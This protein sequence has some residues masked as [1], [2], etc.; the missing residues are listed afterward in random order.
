MPFLTFRFAVL[1]SLVLV[2]A[3]LSPMA[4]Q[5]KAQSTCVNNGA[6]LCKPVS[7]AAGAASSPANQANNNGQ[8]DSAKNLPKGCKAG[9]MRCMNSTHRM[10]AA[11][12]NA[13]RRAAA[14]QKNLT[15]PTPQGEVK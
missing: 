12:R 7:I 8:T 11:I 14:A 10:E 2:L 9:Q 1:L 15:A 6:T 4:G 3:T 13:D 5:T